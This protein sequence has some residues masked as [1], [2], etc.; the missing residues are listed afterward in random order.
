[1]NYFNPKII[2]KNFEWIFY[3]LQKDSIMLEK[4]TLGNTMQNFH[5]RR[6]PLQV[7]LGFQKSVVTVCFSVN[8][9]F[10]LDEELLNSV[11]V[12]IFYVE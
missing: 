2:G 9:S 11:L 6:F 1:M 4:I 8:M 3:V 7:Y 5:E 12:L 10:G